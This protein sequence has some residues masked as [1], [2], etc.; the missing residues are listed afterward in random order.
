[1]EELAKHRVHK[2]REHHHHHH[3]HLFHLPGHHHKEHHQQQTGA[4]ENY[5]VVSSAIDEPTTHVAAPSTA[6]FK[7]TVGDDGRKL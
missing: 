3:M 5:R 4:A 7:L 2:E 6:H 1:M